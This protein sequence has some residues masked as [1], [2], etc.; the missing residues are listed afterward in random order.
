MSCTNL[1]APDSH[2]NPG[3]LRIEPKWPR[4]LVAV[5]VVVVVVVHFVV[6]VV[7]FVG[8]F[9]HA[10]KAPP[11]ALPPPLPP[12]VCAARSVATP[13]VRSPT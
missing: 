4:I 2:T 12:P 10:L 8:L 6:V 13:M 3:G 9:T 11:V 5:V 7:L 1:K